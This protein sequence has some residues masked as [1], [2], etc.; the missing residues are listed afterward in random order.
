MKLCLE[1]NNIQNLPVGMYAVKYTA[2]ILFTATSPNGNFEYGYHFSNE[3]SYFYTS[4]TLRERL[5]TH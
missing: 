1:D 3:L 2:E 4:K 5:R